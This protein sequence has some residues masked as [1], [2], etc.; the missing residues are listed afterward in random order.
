MEQ[1]ELTLHLEKTRIVDMSEAEAYF[2]YLGYRFKRSRRTGKLLRLA[3]PKSEKKLRAKIKI[4]TKRCNGHSMEAIIAKLNPTLRGW[5][6]I[7]SRRTI[8]S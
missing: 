4:M 8:L 5:M 1:A 6:G 7:T 3:R 2:D